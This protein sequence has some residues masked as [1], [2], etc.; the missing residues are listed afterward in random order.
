M[1]DTTP[2]SDRQVSD[3]LLR[4]ARSADSN[5]KYAR[6]RGYAKLEADWKMTAGRIYALLDG[7]WYEQRAFPF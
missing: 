5:A 2:R 7:H 1:P 4:A 3:L 6:E